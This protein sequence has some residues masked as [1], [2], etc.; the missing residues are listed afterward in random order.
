[1][2]EH[3]SCAAPSKPW[4][5]TRLLEIS[6]T[7]AGFAVHLVETS[8]QESVG[9]YRY[10]ALSHMWG[11]LTSPAP[12][13]TVAGNIERLRHC[14]DPGELPR[15]FIDAI[16]VCMR[17]G[18]SYVWIDSL[19]IIQDSD[20]DWEREAVLMH[21]VYRHA[22]T[23]IVATSATSSYDGFLHRD[24]SKDLA[25]KVAYSTIGEDTN[26]S[27]VEHQKYFVASLPSIYY[28]EWYPFFAINASVWNTRGWTMQERC[29][30]TRMLHFCRNKLFFECRAGIQSEEGEPEQEKNLTSG[31]LWP[32]C[33]SPSPSADFC[34]ELYTRWQFLLTEYSLRRLTYGSDR[35]KAVQSVANEM[36]TVATGWE[37]LDFAGMWR[38]NLARELLWCVFL[39]DATRPNKSRAPTWSWGSLDAQVLFN[40]RIL[41][42]TQRSISRN[43][44]SLLNKHPFEVRGFGKT[45]LGHHFGEDF[46]GYLEVRTLARRVSSFRRLEE[47]GRWRKFFPYNLSLAIDTGSDGKPDLLAIERVFAHGKLDLDLSD[48]PQGRGRELLYM[49]VDIGTRATGLILEKSLDIEQ[50]GLKGLWRRV[51]L[52][53]LFEDRTGILIMDDTFG[54]DEVH[55]SLVLI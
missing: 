25:V 21:L 15:N 46:H 36:A 20:E 48:S 24:Y 38:H 22:V 42:N 1:M 47:P 49:H 40:T 28:Q 32:R 41:S 39:G 50:K 2:R 14:I 31:V 37:Y 44:T 16:L 52:A 4:A 55:Q 27:G 5:P 12:F 11:D 17:L 43:L 3:P 10:A 9:E 6:G 51:G 19:C 13:R 33:A 45:L 30:S 8:F 34:S 29:L 54:G 53:S 35:L 18:I 26:A 7:P 23:T